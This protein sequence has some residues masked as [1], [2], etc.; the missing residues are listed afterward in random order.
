MG[1]PGGGLGVDRSALESVVI[2]VLRANDDPPHT[3]AAI[4][5]SVRS[6]GHRVSLDDVEA[7]CESLVA[8]GRIDFLRGGTA[9]RYVLVPDRP[10]AADALPA[11]MRPTRPTPRPRTQ[12]AGTPTHRPDEAGGPG[13]SGSVG[14]ERP[15]AAS[16]YQFVENRPETYWGWYR[17]AL[18]LLFSFDIL[19]TLA[20]TSIYG[21]R[22][23]VNP[24]MV[25]LIERGP[26]ALVVINLLALVAVVYAFSW[27]IDAIRS[28]PDPYDIVL[29]LVVEAWLVF[30]V[31]AGLFV[32]ANNTA[33]VLLGRS[34][35]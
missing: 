18:Y 21:T 13:A 23:E 31:A 12:F 28:A 1:L 32:A 11:W 16:N 9:R 2:D 24:I 7:A 20:A 34:I 26:V 5:R 3:A 30:L 10:D 15:S 19:T 8:D 35:I 22:A 27:V 6:A 4:H 17:L 14:R 25:W 29:E 33:V